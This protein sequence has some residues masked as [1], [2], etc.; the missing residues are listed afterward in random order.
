M[1]ADDA[2]VDFYAFNDLLTPEERA[3]RQR[4]RTFVDERILPTINERWERAEMPVELLPELGKLGIVGGAIAGYGC[5][6]L[7]V[8][9]AGVTTMELARGDGSINTILAVQSGLAMPAIYYLG[10]EE[11]RLR[12][13]PPLARG[14]AIGAFGL[15][16]PTNGSDASHLQTTAH[17]EGDYYVL[18]GDKRWIGNASV[19]D[20]TVI[21][22]RDDEGHLG[23]FLVEKGSSGFQA[24]VI[25]GK[26]AAR[27]VW[28][29][30][31]VLENCRVPV[32]NRLPRANSFR[33]TTEIL[34]RGRLGVSWSAIGHAHACY[35]TA[36]SYTRQR[37]QFG[38]PLAA[39]QLVQDKLVRM[40]AEITAMQL[41]S[42]RASK[43]CEEGRLTP[44]MASL[45]KMNN[46]SK[47]RRIAADARDLLGGNGILLEHHVIRHLLDVEAIFTY[48]GTDH[49]NSLLIGR[50]ITGLSA[51]S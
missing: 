46:A 38:K 50:E 13:L 40:L 10:S 9:G 21:W 31:I 39:F 36:L 19:A 6:G 27:A 22:G 51:F 33:D 34:Q 47:A 26:G 2:S 25:T 14:E 28:Q 44:A 43:L 41:L 4:V 16:E 20:V 8:V 3:V 7:S 1:I 5:P 35:E 11:Q 42:W 23:G 48:E 30:D 12:W 49:M 17:R 18:N 15:T 24:S 29:T 37:Q 45:A 32:E